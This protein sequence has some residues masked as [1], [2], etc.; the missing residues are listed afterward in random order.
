MCAIEDCDPADFWHHST[1]TARQPHR[2]DE[3]GRAVSPAEKYD[4]YTWLYEGRWSRM[5]VCAH[6]S[7]AGEWL[8][9][10]CGGWPIG[11]L[12]E[13]LSEHWDEGYRSIGFARLIVGFGRRWRD[14]TDLIPTGVAE[15][16]RLMMAKQV[17]A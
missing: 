12:G 16:A 6:C 8:N 17:A 9:V 5:K 1:R 11:G 2:C 4:L 13:E 3:C 7:A 10:M 15:L 14:G